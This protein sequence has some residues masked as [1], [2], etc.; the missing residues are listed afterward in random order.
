M[1]DLSESVCCPV[2]LNTV[3]G[4]QMTEFK[5]QFDSEEKTCLVRLFDYIPGERFGIRNR[6]AIYAQSRSMH[7]R[8]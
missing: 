3:R 2:P 6:S 7:T 8:F 1:S 4:T 5:A